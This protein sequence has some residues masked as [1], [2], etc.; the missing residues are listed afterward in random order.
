SVNIFKTLGTWL[1]PRR[2]E[3]NSRCGKFFLYRRVSSNNII[4]HDQ[5]SQQHELTWFRNVATNKRS[6]LLMQRLLQ[7]IN[8][9]PDLFRSDR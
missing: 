6:R 3:F 5:T 8:E 9:Y 1:S 4:P 2:P 7:H